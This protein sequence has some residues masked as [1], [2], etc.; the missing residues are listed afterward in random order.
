[1]FY[2]QSIT[3]ATES[4]EWVATCRAPMNTANCTYVI[5]AVESST[6]GV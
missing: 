1:M 5:H 3:C 4:E 6:H 2:K